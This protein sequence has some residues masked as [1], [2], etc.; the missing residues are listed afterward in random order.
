MWKFYTTD[1]KVDYNLFEEVFEWYLRTPEILRSSWEFEDDKKQFIED[2][3]NG[4]NFAG[5]QDDL[6]C[7]MVHGQEKEPGVIEGHLFC[8]SKTGVDFL[9]ALITYSK[10][11]ALTRYV[12]VLT[13]TPIK[14]KTMLEINRRAG[15]IDT[16]I[17]SWSGVYRGRLLEIQHNIAQ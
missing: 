5:E 4:M 2:L 16:G 10:N 15:F 17:R 7:A 13:Q 12:S 14:H 6:F 8:A 1:T 11:Q 9:T 3:G